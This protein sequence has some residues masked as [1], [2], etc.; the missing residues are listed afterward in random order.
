MIRTAWSSTAILLEKG[1][2]NFP[3]LS[4][5][6]RAWCAIRASDRHRGRAFPAAGAALRAH[7]AGSR[8]CASRWTTGRASSR[9]AR[10]RRRGGSPTS[11]CLLFHRSRPASAALL[12]GEFATTMSGILVR[13]VFARLARLGARRRDARRFAL[14]LAKVRRPGR[15]AETRGFVLGR[16][17]EQ[18]FERARRGVHVRVRIADLREALRNR[19]HGEVGRIAVGDLVP[20][21]RRG[22]A[23]VGKR[24]HRIRRARG[25]ILGVLVVV[26]EHAVALFLPPFRSG[27]RRRAPLDRARQARAPRGALR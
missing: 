16:E 17:L 6:T 11:A 12:S 2:H 15:V 22:H 27:E 24:A 25:A 26:E 3:R 14:H 21:K 23:R 10:R 18:F 9:P 19:E 20:V 7:G 5:S 1:T 13:G 4:S 8:G